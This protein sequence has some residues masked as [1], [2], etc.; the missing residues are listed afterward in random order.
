MLNKIWFGLLVIGLFYGFGK[1]VYKAAMATSPSLASAPTTQSE[2]PRPFTDMG[3][4]LTTDMI[5]AARTS[6]DLCLGLIGAMAL[7]LGFMKIAE[8]SGLIAAIARMLRPIISRI[9]PEIPR[10]HPAGGAII[11]NFAANLLGLDNAAT[12]LGLKAMKELESLNPHQGTATNS[13]AM[14]LAL[15]TGGLTLIPFSIISY[16]IA[17]GSKDPAA[18]IVAMILASTC[19]T[20]TAMIAARVLQR[21]Y[22]TTS[23]GIP[24][25]DPAASSKENA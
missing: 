22:P 2:P 8:D 5:D 20:I 1:G 15:N 7:W 3:K 10:D 16:R 9:F 24:V 6:V 4:K 23:G 14:F 13:M 17:A 18:P 21:F 19:T 11:M 25:A 12:P